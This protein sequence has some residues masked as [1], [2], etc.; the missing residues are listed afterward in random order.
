MRN[1]LVLTYWSFKDPLFKTYTL[2]Y[3]YILRKILNVKDTITVITF[4]NIY[5]TS[6]N[7]KVELKKIFAEKNISLINFQ[8]RFHG[9]FKLLFLSLQSL[10]VIILLYYK[11]INI[12]HSFCTPA[13]SL[14]YILSKFKKITLIL[15]S[16]EPHADSMVENGTWEFNS[17]YFKILFYLEN[18][19]CN[20][21]NIFICPS[22]SMSNYMLERSDFIPKQMFHKPAC[23]DTNIFNFNQNT[24][25]IRN[26][27]NL[28]NKIICV[29]AG[30]IGGIYLTNEIF[31]FIKECINFWK[32]RFVFLLLSD[33]NESILNF[34]LKRLNIDNN[35]VILKKVDHEEVNKYLA[36]ASFAI[37]FVKPVPSKRY[38][39]SIKDGEYWASGLPIIITKNI[40]DDSEIINQTGFGYELKELSPIEYLNAIYLIDKLLV[41]D[42]ILYVKT[43]IREMAFKYRNFKIATSIYKEI[44]INN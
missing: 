25:L 27:Y 13:G 3:I 1:I 8:Y 24:E 6:R 26:K 39:T 14:G 16:F 19:L 44:Y 38:C 31:D 10:I 33:C 28:N 17:I 35:F 29:Y 4:E 32:K 40:G 22:K 9:I 7:D 37:N 36:L 12:I 21:S 18:K 42:N 11:K 23:V 30:K 34:Q 5:I 20:N 2:P 15:D 41:Q 43:K